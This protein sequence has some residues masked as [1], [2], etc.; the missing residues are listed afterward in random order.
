MFQWQ[1]HSQLSPYPH[2][3]LPAEVIL[4]C[5][6]TD[7]AGYKQALTKE[8]LNYIS[9]MFSSSVSGNSKT[10]NQQGNFCIGAVLRCWQSR[11]C[12]YLYCMG[13]THSSRVNNLQCLSE[14]AQRAHTVHWLCLPWVFC[15]SHCT[16]SAPPLVPCP[17]FWLLRISWRRWARAGHTRARPCPA[18]ACSGTGW[19]SSRSAA[20]WGSP[21]GPGDEQCT[22]TRE[23]G[24]KRSIKISSVL[25]ACS[26]E[27]VLDSDRRNR[28]L[29]LLMGG[30]RVWG[31]IQVGTAI[32][33]TPKQQC[34]WEKEIQA[35]PQ[36][37]VP[38]NPVFTYLFPTHPPL[39][40]ACANTEFCSSVGMHFLH[41]ASVSI[42]GNKFQLT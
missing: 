40:V 37:Q 42:L 36:Q 33:R 25:L 16:C 15:P 8:L 12:V 27:K 38:C 14:V 11:A 26:A 29:C 6:Y 39:Q 17:G 18:T 7:L 28:Q 24:G 23:R 32:T 31:K 21:S 34:T 9:A 35:K 13:L 41:W 22:E 2:F 10:L 3:W 20:P 1:L 19:P 4:L 30:D 5:P